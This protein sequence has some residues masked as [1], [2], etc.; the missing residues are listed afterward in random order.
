MERTNQPWKKLR[1]AY[2]LGLF[3]IAYLVEMANLP[4]FM[5]SRKAILDVEPG[6][7]CTL[8]VCQVNMLSEISI[9]IRII[10]WSIFRIIFALLVGCFVIF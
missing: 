6:G 3:P 4:K 1:D 2:M 10:S 5:Y 7:A 9:I 8:V